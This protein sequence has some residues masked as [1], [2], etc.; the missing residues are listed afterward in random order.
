MDAWLT[1]VGLTVMGLW[2]GIVFSDNARTTE[3]PGG[4][5]KEILSQQRQIGNESIVSRR[6]QIVDFQNQFAG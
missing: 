2:A 3:I 6:M 4:Y 5:V 1:G